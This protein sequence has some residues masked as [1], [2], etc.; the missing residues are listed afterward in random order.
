MSCLCEL[1]RS[2]PCAKN[3]LRLSSPAGFRASSYQIAA[4][5]T[6]SVASGPCLESGCEHVR[7]RDSKR[8]LSVLR[9]GLIDAPQP[10]ALISQL[11]LEKHEVR[12]TV[13]LLN[14]QHS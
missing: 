6:C 8:L 7:T 3:G 1:V 5:W 10:W 14:E 9:Y 4:Q 11:P 13:L 12:S 2:I